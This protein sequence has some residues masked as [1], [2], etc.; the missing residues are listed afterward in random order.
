MKNYLKYLL[1]ATCLHWLGG[2]NYKDAQHVDIRVLSEDVGFGVMLEM[3]MIPPIGR[4]PLRKPSFNI[5]VE[6]V[7]KEIYEPE[8][9]PPLNGR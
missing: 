9:E 8:H 3:A 1:C 5:Y 2:S 7:R 4:S 6:N